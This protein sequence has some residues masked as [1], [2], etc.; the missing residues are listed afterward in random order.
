MAA[1]VKL[2]GV[3]GICNPML[4]HIEHHHSTDTWH[5]YNA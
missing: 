5:L 1:F 4:Y 3:I 2:T